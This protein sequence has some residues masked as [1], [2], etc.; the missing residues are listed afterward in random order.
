MH[1]HK[2]GAQS[3]HRPEDGEA[4]FLRNEVVPLVYVE[5]VRPI[6]NGMSFPLGIDLENS[7]INLAIA[8]VRINGVY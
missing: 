5:R 7:K 8:R 2:V 3:S 6:A 4:P 1:S